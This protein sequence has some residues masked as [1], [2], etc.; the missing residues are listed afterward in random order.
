MPF[1]A[2]DAV[3]AAIAAQAIGS[4]AGAGMANSANA[5]LS[6][7]SM[8]W[9]EGQTLQA[10][11]YATRMSNTA[12]Q[13]RVADLRAAGLNPMLAYTQGGASAPQVSTSSAPNTPRMDNPFADVSKGMSSAA[14]LMQTRQNMENAKIANAK[15]ATDMAVNAQTVNTGKAQQQLLEA[16]AKLAASNTR[17]RDVDTKKT[18]ATLPIV[19]QQSDV[20]QSFG[21]KLRAY[22]DPYL[23]LAQDIIGTINPI[24][25]I[26]RTGRV[27]DIERAKVGM[28]D[29][30][31]KANMARAHALT[32][33]K[34]VKQGTTTETINP[35]TGTVN[36]VVRTRHHY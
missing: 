5:A 10:Q 27:S 20:A 1:G 29:A 31:A 13:R 26:L 32:Q 8:R 36:R 2:D 22:A 4:I 28:Y 21:G 3:A 24:N 23:G 30:S 17:G 35:H 6:G 7:K 15:V 14:Q 19:Q 18:E 9:Q 11:D 16:Q 12:M 34:V 25:A 33:P